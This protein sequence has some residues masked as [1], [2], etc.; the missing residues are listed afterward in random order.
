MK[1][2][3]VLIIQFLFFAVPVYS[4]D[5]GAE[6]T[7]H[8]LQFKKIEEIS[9]EREDLFLSKKQIQVSMTFMN[10]SQTNIST[11][12]A[13]PIPEYKYWF[14][15]QR[16]DFK[17][18]NVIVDGNVLDFQTEARAFLNGKE[19]TKLLQNMNISVH[20]F[21]AFEPDSTTSYFTRLSASQRIE[22]LNAGLVDSSG[23]PKWSVKLKYFWSQIFPANTRINIKHSYT[24][25]YGYQYFMLEDYAD[26][27]SQK[28][29]KRD[30]AFLKGDACLS[31]N[32]MKT[33]ISMY[34]PENHLTPTSWV[35]YVLKSA[36]N[37][38]QPIK[39]FHLVVEKPS[40]E[41]ISS[42]YMRYLKQVEANKYEATL[43]NF[44]PDK[45]IRIYFYLIAP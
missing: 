24:P 3:S 1:T 27:Q 34:T 23:W 4:D 22:L 44:V 11:T 40:D 16:A 39:T 2:T 38:K 19:F 10:H 29:V 41:F 7:P 28:E 26:G 45:D 5:S 8:G 6:V 15:R 25:I 18:F 20:D 36:L 21:G 17:D 30:K 33:L 14:D 31:N 9:V 37:W 43:E 13:F 35:S 42:C 32:E 12:I